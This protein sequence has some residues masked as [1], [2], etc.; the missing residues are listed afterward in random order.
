MSS[1]NQVIELKKKRKRYLE[2]L[3]SSLQ[4]QHELLSSSLATTL[5]SID[6]VRLR[7]QLQNVEEYIESVSNDLEKL[8][9]E[10]L[11]QFN[12]INQG[13]DNLMSKLDAL[14]DLNLGRIVAEQDDRKGSPPPLPSCQ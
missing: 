14:R 5:D 12:Q 10:T 4:E 13:N 9:R 3:L 8:E 2:D 1:F 11:E 7:R 6:K